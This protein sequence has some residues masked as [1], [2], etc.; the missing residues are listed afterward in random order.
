MSQALK[1]NFVFE[2]NHQNRIH[3]KIKTRL[4][5][6]HACY[7]LAQNLLCSCLLSKI[8]KI[9][10]YRTIILP[11]VLYGCESWTV[12]LWEEHR[13]MVFKNRVL[14]EMWDLRGKYQETGENCIMESIMV[15]TPHQM[16]QEWSIY[17]TGNVRIT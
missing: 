17:K 5:S 1:Y 7:H 12:R 15:C 3:E 4:N 6:K 2:S 10:I 8:M 11:V 13:L 9:K 14:R 16:L